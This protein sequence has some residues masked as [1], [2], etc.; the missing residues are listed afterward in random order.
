MSCSIQ[1]FMQFTSQ[2][3]VERTR[4][5]E[6]ATVKEQG[7]LQHLYVMYI[8]SRAGYS[9]SV[10][11]LLPCWSHDNFWHLLKKHLGTLHYLYLSGGGG[12]SLLSNF[13]CV[14]INVTHALF[15]QYNHRNNLLLQ[16]KLP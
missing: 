14:S 3:L 4:P 2:I 11:E 12:G 16:S 7:R 15:H 5:N 13:S 8:Y 6:R 1:E 9:S 10:T